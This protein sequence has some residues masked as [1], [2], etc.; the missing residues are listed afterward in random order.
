MNPKKDEG[1][2]S[3]AFSAV[4]PI[5]LGCRLEQ[6]QAQKARAAMSFFVVH[7]VKNAGNDDFNQFLLDITSFLC[8]ICLYT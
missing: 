8:I 7:K 5:S 4:G 6:K 2:A 3:A 1:I